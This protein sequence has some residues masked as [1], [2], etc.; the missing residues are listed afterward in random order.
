[1][2]ITLTATET[3][4]TSGLGGTQNNVQTAALAN[5]G[6]VV[7]WNTDLG[8]Q[9]DILFQIYDAAGNQVGGPTACQCRALTTGDQL[10]TD[11]IGTDDGHFVLAFTDSANPTNVVVRSYDEVTGVQTGTNTVTVTGTSATG[12][13]LLA[14]T[15]SRF[16]VVSS[17]TRAAIRPSTK[18]SFPR[19]AA[20]SPPM[21]M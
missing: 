14:T 12:A 11:I 6:Y 18:P 4:N 21:P 2:A 16:E 19:P 9:K 20:P 8:G 10:I 7:A 15:A 3:V 5:G 1:M 13:Q 17:G